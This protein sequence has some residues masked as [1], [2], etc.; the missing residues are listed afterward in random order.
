MNIFSFE[1]YNNV[2]SYLMIISSYLKA[3]I[4]IQRA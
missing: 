3:E 4:K 2:L 1:S